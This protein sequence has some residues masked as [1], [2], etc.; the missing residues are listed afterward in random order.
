MIRFAPDSYD[1]RRRPVGSALAL[2]SLLLAASAGAQVERTGQTAGGA[3]YRIVVP[4]GWTPADGLVIYNHGFDLDPPGP[5]PEL[6]PLVDVQLAEGYAVAASSYSLNGWALFR[7]RIDNRELVDVFTS[8]FGTPDEV[9]VTGASLGGIVTV[10]AIESGEMGN[11]VGGLSLCGAVAGSRLWDGALDLRLLYDAVCGEV[12]GAAI[13]GGAGGLPYPPD[14]SL[15]EVT[16]LARV[17]AC[18]GALLPDALRSSDQIERRERLLELTRLPNEEFLL[19]DLGYAT[20]GLSDLINDPRKLGGASPFTNALVEYGDPEIDASI[21][22]VSADPEA[23]RFFLENYTPTGEVGDAKVVAL[24]TDK[25]GLVPV[26]NTSEYAAVMPAGRLTVG[27]VVEE[28][29]SHCGFADTEV[30]AAWESL[31]EWVEG[32]PQ[33]SASDLQ[34]TCESLAKD[35][36]A[37]GPCRIDPGFVVPD[38]DDR[39]RPRGGACVQD[40]DTFCLGADGR[41]RAEVVWEDFSGNTGR[42]R[43][44]PFNTADSGSFWFFDPANVEMIVKVLDARNVNGRFWVFYGSLTN[45]E[46]ELKVTD[47]ETGSER[48]YRNEPGVFASRGDTEAF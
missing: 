13:P 7:T 24:Q 19:V 32:A 41:F 12:P 10:Q 16:L 22:R 3:Y 33:P 44:T 23:R 30:L 20:F 31:R 2:V 1:G 4:E 35:G 40:Q 26:E 17:V 5:R 11:V 9:F 39:I 34:A 43:T 8:M 27:I 15:T 29:P 21:E 38:F 47:T 46:F 14:P 28:E 48:I 37:S 36:A 18:T 42:G 6:G 25:D 45:V